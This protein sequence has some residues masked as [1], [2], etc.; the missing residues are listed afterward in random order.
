MNSI[1]TDLT[2]VT[3]D[4]VIV[5]INETTPTNSPNCGE[6]RNGWDCD[7]SPG[8][9]LIL[10][11]RFGICGLGFLFNIIVL[12]L[13]IKIR[14]YDRTQYVFAMILTISD[15]VHVVNVFAE[16]YF[17]L[18][19][20]TGQPPSWCS[21]IAFAS[22]LLSYLSIVAVAVD[23]YL[24]LC[25]IPLKYKHAVTIQKYWLI[26]A[27]MFLFS[28]ICG[29]SFFSSVSHSAISLTYTSVIAPTVIISVTCIVY[30]RLVYL[31]SKSLREIKVSS[32]RKRHRNGQTKRLI[33]AFATILVANFACNIPQSLFSLYIVLQPPDN[34]Y[35]IFK[36]AVLRNWIYNI[37]TFHTCVNPII[38]WYQ[39]L[40]KEVHL[41]LFSTLCK[42][43]R[44]TESRTDSPKESTDAKR[45]KKLFTSFRPEL[46]Q[47]NSLL[48]R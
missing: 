5:D 12:I 35:N 20:H 8:I 23:R 38:F 21:A 22:S 10:L 44:A 37:Q 24:A 14:S 26:I 47:P 3:S 7:E 33:V 19:S 31:V 39:V 27:F 28:L 48:A 2:Y 1:S 41:P 17:F 36:H 29:Y 11:L 30:V 42:V 4:D 46:S 25:V 32:N 34:R 13:Q 15:I 45:S 16:T 40:V 9:N 6:N 43:I 18:Q